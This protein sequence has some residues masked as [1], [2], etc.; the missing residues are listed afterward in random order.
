VL[1]G[2]DYLVVIRAQRLAAADAAVWT[3]KRLTRRHGSIYRSL[4]LLA[5]VLAALLGIGATLTMGIVLRRGVAEIQAGLLA[6]ETDFTHELPQRNDELGSISR[7]INRMAGVRRRL[8][9]DLRRQDRLRAVGGMVAGIAH[10]IRNPLN[11]IRLSMQSLEQR[12]RTRAVRHEDLELV[13][14]EVD[15]MEALLGDLLAFQSRTV[16]DMTEQLVLPV[17]E[18]CVRLVEPQTSGSQASI[19]LAAPDTS[20]RAGFDARALTQVLMNL[21]LNAVEATPGNA[22]VD[23]QL[24][25]DG[26]F[27]A[28]VIRDN[29][30]GLSIEQ[31]E[32]L[33]EAFYTT[34][35]EGTGLGLAVSRE[36]VEAMGG[37]LIYRDGQ[38]GATFV[39][40]LPQVG[41]EQG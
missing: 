18:R 17:V 26:D 21:L 7:S 31:R 40:Q 36:L 13:I 6:L 8:E 20:L 2:G 3:M 16:P 29:G 38:P 11:G 33:F 34:K 28:I 1:R 30:P 14:E 32:H 24:E 25:K 27:A 19:R 35:P 15:R 9:A 5:F 37:C 23:V 22:T 41:H 10:E 12:V 4:L 39:I